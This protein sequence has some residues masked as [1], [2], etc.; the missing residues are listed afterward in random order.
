MRIFVWSI[1]DWIISC[2][3]CVSRNCDRHFPPAGK[4]SVL[5]RK[6][7]IVVE[8]LKYSPHSAERDL[9]AMKPI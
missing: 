9:K 3:I 1:S 2:A 4:S 8:K 5:E 7:K 6:V